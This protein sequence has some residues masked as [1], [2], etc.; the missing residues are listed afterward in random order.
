MTWRI[1]AISLFFAALLFN[2]HPVWAIDLDRTQAI[3]I[4]SDSAVID[5]T[6]G[7]STYRG[8]VIIRQGSSQLT[9]D[10]ISVFARDHSVTQIIANGAP[11]KFKQ[12]D[13]SDSKATQGQADQITY[14]SKDAVLIFDGNA[15][16]E[17]ATNSFSGNRIEYDIMRKAIRAKG[18]QD[19]G[20][21]VKIQYYPSQGTPVDTKTDQLDKATSDEQ[22]NENPTR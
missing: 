3:E 5:D 14:K 22:Y 8:N 4:E 18:D 7:F 9:A 21:R 17:Q 2:T 1:K 13:P 16:L 11:A 20:Q 12:Q 19:T 6:Q 10:N 15:T